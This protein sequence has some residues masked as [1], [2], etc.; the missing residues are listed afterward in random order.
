[1][2][3]TKSY[4]FA[5]DPS[6]PPHCKEGNVLDHQGDSEGSSDSVSSGA[7]AERTPLP[8]SVFVLNLDELQSAHAGGIREAC[9]QPP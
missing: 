2:H 8:Y 9:L 3:H 6:D 7:A 4:S 5:L 1:M